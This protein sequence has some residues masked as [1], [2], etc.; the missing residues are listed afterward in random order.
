MASYQE[1][2]PELASLLGVAGA[3]AVMVL[4]ESVIDLDGG[5]VAVNE[6]HN[7]VDAVLV[8]LTVHEQIT[9]TRG[10]LRHRRH[11]CQQPAVPD[12]PLPDVHGVRLVAKQRA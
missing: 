8:A 3:W 2:R 11:G 10:L 7:H 5:P 6:K 4:E 12:A 1:Q 9:D